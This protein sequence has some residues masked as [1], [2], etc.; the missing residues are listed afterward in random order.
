[1]NPQAIPQTQIQR[2]TIKTVS[3]G[4][5]HFTFLLVKKSFITVILFA[6]FLTS[7]NP[8]QL[9]AVNPN[10]DSSHSLPN[11]KSLITSF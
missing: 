7:L 11:K 1:M 9:V 2:V 10:E 6:N 5:F 3:K 4:H 8:V